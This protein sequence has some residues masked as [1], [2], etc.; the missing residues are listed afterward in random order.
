MVASPRQADY[1]ARNAFFQFV[2]ALV[3]QESGGRYGAVGVPTRYGRALGRYQIL[4]SNLAAWGREAIG[5]P[6]TAAEFM[7][8]HALQDQIALFKLSQYVRQ[9]GFAGAAVAWYAGPGAAVAY[10]QNP[11]QSRFT[12]KQGAFPSIA[13][14]AASVVSRARTAPTAPVNIA[15][16][17]AMAHYQYGPVPRVSAPARGYAGSPNSTNPGS[18]VG[19]EQGARG[20]TTR[21]GLPAGTKTGGFLTMAGGGGGA[22]TTGDVLGSEGLLGLGPTGPSDRYR[23]EDYGF[24]NAFFSTN[25]ELRGLVDRAVKGDWDPQKFQIELKKT[26]WYQTTSL[27]DREW[28]ALRTGD[29]ATANRRLAI[30]KEQVKRA[31]ASMGA[32]IDAKTLENLSIQALRF[33]YS[34]QEIGARLGT[35][36]RLINGEMRGEAG[37]RLDEFRQLA[38]DY[39]ITVDDKRLAVHVQRIARGEST[40]EELDNW[41]KAQ[42]KAM[43]PGLAKMIDAGVSVEDVARQYKQVMQEVLEV[44]VESVDLR[45]NPHLR[46]ALTYKPEKG[47]PAP[48]AI[49]EFERMLRDDPRW[50][51]TDNARAQLSSVTSKVMQDFGFRS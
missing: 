4:D 32:V 22:V 27:A 14:Y 36:V 13:Q 51:K 1:A 38:H 16:R 29:P 45:T 21:P 28:T 7:R 2:N 30:M 11:N 12:R 17:E 19:A 40:Q 35:F 3:V 49:H 44:D 20:S 41:L 50:L 10:I 6:V 37:T 42:A 15:W 9:F 24:A 43:Y 39:G 46:K 48:M 8:N 25:P 47:E 26:K 23:L 34:E 33:G 18:A 5:R 31:A